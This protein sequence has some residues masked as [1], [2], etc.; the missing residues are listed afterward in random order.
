MQPVAVCEPF[1]RGD[2]GAV[3]GDREHKA[4]VHPPAVQQDR[5]GAALALIASLLRA[6]PAQPLPQNVEQS[7]AVVHN[8]TLGLLVHGEGDLG[9]QRRGE[10]VAFCT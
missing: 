1:D 7:A 8:E 10:R 2:L 3:L 4:A 5:A 9:L 6:G